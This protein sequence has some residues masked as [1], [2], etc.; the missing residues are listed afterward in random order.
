MRG[1]PRRFWILSLFL[2]TL[3]LGAWCWVRQSGLAPGI[4]E[5]QTLKIVATLPQTQVDDTDRL[6]I[7]FNGPAV[8]AAKVGKV[9]DAPLF[10]VSPDVPGQWLWSSAERLDFVLDD[11]LPAGRTINVQPSADLEVQLGRAVQ[12]SGEIQFQTRALELEHC[13]ILS[14]GDDAISFELIFNQKVEPAALLRHLKVQEQRGQ[15]SLFSASSSP[16]SANGETKSPD[17]FVQSLN[18]TCLTTGPNHRLVLR[19]DR[20]Q[21]RTFDVVL[22]ADLKGPDAERGLGKIITRNLTLARTFALLR[23][24][25]PEI[26]IAKHLSVRLFFSGNLDPDQ[27][28]PPITIEPS[29]E[30]FSTRTDHQHWSR[31]ALVLEGKFQPGRTYQVLVGKT[32]LSADGQTLD[33]DARAAFTVP[34]REPTVH[35][36][37]NRGVLSPQGNLALDVETVNVGQLKFK[38]TRIHANNLVQHLQGR[39]TFDIGRTVIEKTIQIPGDRSEPRTQI[40][41]LKKLL[42]QETPLGIYEIEARATDENWRRDEATVTITDLALITKREADGVWVWVSSLKTAQPVAGVKVSAISYTNQTLASAQTGADGIARLLVSPKH[43]DGAPWVITAE[44]GP[45]LAYLLTER[46]EWVVDDVDQTGRPHPGAYDVLLYTERGVYRPGDTLHVTG[47]IRDAQGATPP[48]FPLA[49]KV[50]RPDGRTAATVTVTPEADKQGTFHF[51][52]PT[53]DD[54]Q[55]G[56]YEFTATLPGAEQVLGDS[57]TLV[58][59]F[60]PARIEVLAEPLSPRVGPT[61]KAAVKVTGRYLFGQPAAELPLTVTGSYQFVPFKSKAAAEFDF[62]ID[63]STPRANIQLPATKLDALGMAQVELP[64]PP[65]TP[66]GIWKA[67]LTTTVTEPGG[68]SISQNV[69]LLWDTADRH[70]GV[71]L[72]TILPVDMAVPVDFIQW[73]GTDVAAAAGPVQFILERI[74]YDTVLRQ[75]SGAY[76][77]ISDERASIVHQ[78]TIDG[79]AIQNGKGQVSITCPTPGSYR[80]RAIDKLSGRSTVARCHASSQSNESNS[81]ALNKPE[82]L[83]IVLDQPKYKPGSTAKILVKSPF[84]GTLVLCVETDRVIEQRVISLPENTTTLEYPIPATLRGGAFITA[85]V[86]RAIVPEDKSWLPHRAFGLARIITDHADHELPIQMRVGRRETGDLRLESPMR[87]EPGEVAAVSLQTAKPES[88]LPVPLVHLWAVDEGILLTT[89]YPTPNP[90]LHFLG[91]RKLG[92]TTEDVY[93]DLLPDH[94]R[95]A[96]WSRIGGDG[97]K[98]REIDGQRR[99]LVPPKKIDMAVLWR[100]FAPV[101]AEGHA[102]FEFQLPQFTGELRFMA[103]V[104][105]GDKYGSTQQ[106]L[107][108][109]SP[110]LLEANWPRFIA[111]GD[112]VSVPVKLFN[113]TD[114]PLSAQLNLKVEG[115][116]LVTLPPET[117]D[118]VVAPN[119]PT[120]VWL[121]VRGTGMGTAEIT[122]RAVANAAVANAASVGGVPGVDHV[123]ATKK[124][125]ELADA[126]SIR[127]VS[128]QVAQLPVRSGLPLHSESV[129]H[130]GTAGTP[131]EVALS[132]TFEPGTFQTQVSISARPA[133]E[134]LP[135]ADS[136][137]QYPYGCVEQTSSRLWALLA[138]KD[139][140]Q[141]QAA[142]SGRER[143]VDSMIAAG[144][145]RLWS[146]QTRGGGLGYWPGADHPSTWGTVYAAEV[147][148]EAAQQGHAVDSQFRDELLSYLTNMLHGQYELKTDD[149]TLQTKAQIC[150]VLAKFNRPEV[151]WMTRLTEQVKELDMSSR[152]DLAVAWHA[153]GRKDRALAVFTDDTL[154]QAIPV[155]FHQRI[156]SPVQQT[157]TLLNAL[158]EIDH[159][160]PWVPGLVTKLLESR[161]FGHWGNTAENAMA[162][163][164]LVRFHGIPS[165]P[166]NYSG[167]VTGVTG[168][169]FPFQ[170][171]NPAVFSVANQTGPLKFET[172]GQGQFFVNVTTTG[173]Q[174]AQADLTYDRHL[175]VRRTWTDRLGQPVDPLRVNV[176]DLIQVAVTIRTLPT[177]D[178][179]FIQNVAI[180][181][182]LPGG[183]E[184]ENPRLNTSAVEAEGAENAAA[185]A[186]ANA[187]HVEFLDDRVVLFTSANPQPRTFR[188]ALRAI[189]TGKFASPPIQASCMYSVDYASVHGGGR[190]EIKK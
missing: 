160:H 64:A 151:G 94:Q 118:I 111:P 126:G 112:E 73:T 40:L 96:D 101:D 7:V 147:L 138:A 23:S 26:G 19:C 1:I 183:F 177:A 76:H 32:L 136:L 113:S 184:V 162:L 124:D 43:P 46:R 174:K 137:L 35:F 85:A 15:D 154:T 165:E 173:L 189:S 128:Q 166:A 78:Q 176:G 143:A 33:D 127:Y 16:D 10:K 103:V 48:S 95:P 119:S 120:T 104:V 92:V 45:D 158:L 77:W 91:Q 66:A 169:V 109:T 36:A 152:A 82:R 60:V 110:L 153:S 187:D 186:A 24:E 108:V 18:P 172:I 70:V 11:P 117:A 2:V 100:G 181:D 55:T 98:G 161:R 39:Y 150:L 56:R 102:R 12:I 28:L 139:I 146:M 164:A 68:R 67:T 132:D 175:Q 53:Q 5:Q 25:V 145:S 62:S 141:Q 159:D 93:A 114:K 8:A 131:L 170:H 179:Q 107:T 3:N 65:A 86:V 88:G 21:S 52:F 122:L 61:E 54:S 14:A 182:A 167:T 72:A 31:A 149:V 38:A 178:N 171:V 163:R 97:D 49:I 185:N 13:N 130:R 168:A 155:S 27:K 71:K 57:T 79:E 125:R 121:P 9:E 58:E 44:Q 156:T 34:E 4:G 148:A 59:A 75:V 129:V 144:I 80:L 123:D 116:V 6:S 188:Y 20:P 157:A 37:Q 84:A 135:A 106:A 47:L 51:D 41:E 134:F 69:S 74:E 87:L 133:L 63:T 90:L 50:R 29:V 17:P 190:I 89:R 99:S 140:L 22:E 42:N 180:V 105:D 83:E 115:P 81:V 30:G 142:G